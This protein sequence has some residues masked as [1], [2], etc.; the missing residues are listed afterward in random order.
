MTQA[1][2]K[3]E[4]RCKDAGTDGNTGQSSQAPI[5]GVD[6][7]NGLTEAEAKL[8]LA[9]F[10]ENALVEHRVSAFEQIAHYFWGPIPWMIEIAAALSAAFEPLG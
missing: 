8:R 2:Y 5:Q 1:L 6:E 9:K 7:A 4:P 10:G 3:F